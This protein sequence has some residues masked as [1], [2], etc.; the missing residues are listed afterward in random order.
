MPA[1]LGFVAVIDRAYLD[2]VALEIA[3]R[4]CKFL[5]CCLA[6]RYLVNNKVEVYTLPFSPVDLYLCTYMS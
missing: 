5:Y 4:M 6:C 2:I 3:E 1:G